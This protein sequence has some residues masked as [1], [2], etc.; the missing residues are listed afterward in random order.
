MKVKRRSRNK[1]EKKRRIQIFGEECTCRD[2]FPPRFK[3]ELWKLRA[4]T[5]KATKLSRFVRIVQ[6]ALGLNPSPLHDTY[7]IS[8]KTIVL[9]VR[10]FEFASFS[11]H[12][13]VYRWI[14]LLFVFSSRES[15]N[16]VFVTTRQYA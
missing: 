1:R 12:L 2:F 4:H 7:T 9:S 15:V 10:R 14:A 8:Q 5:E 11:R 13:E 3:L 16:A 6:D